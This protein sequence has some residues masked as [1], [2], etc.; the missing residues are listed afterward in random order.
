MDKR[1]FDYRE[2]KCHFWDGKTDY[3]KIKESEEAQQDRIDQFGDWL[4]R[5]EVGEV[6]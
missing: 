6:T 4:E 1:A 3:R 2:L 5:Q